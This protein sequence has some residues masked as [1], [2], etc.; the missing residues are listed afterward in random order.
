MLLSPS[1]AKSW[2]PKVKYI[3]FD[4]IHS[5]GQAEDGV[6]WEQLLLLAP[7]PI[8]A[9]SATVGNPEM[10]N[11]WLDSTQQSSGH[12]VAM[13]KHQHRYSDLRKFVFNPPKRF[14]FRGLSDRPSFATLGLDGISGFA[15]I[16]PVASLV[17]KSRGIPDDL[18]L[19]AR[20]CLSLYQ[21]MKR[22]ETA[23]YP[24][25]SDLEPSKRL[26]STKVIRKADIIEWEQTLKSLLKAW[27]SDSN[28]PF[29]AVQGELSKSMESAPSS[30]VEASK[31]EI[32]DKANDLTDIDPNDL[33]STTLPLLCKLQERDALPAILFNYDR[34]KCENIVKVVVQQLRDAEHRWKVSSPVWNAKL[35]GFEKWKL[36]K[37]KLGNKKAKVV[38]KKKGK[39]GDDDDPTSKMDNMMDA[40]SEEANPYANFDPEAPVDGFHFAAKHRAE[41]TELAAYFRQMKW[42]YVIMPYVA[43]C[44]GPPQWHQH[45][46]A[47]F[48]RF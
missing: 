42:R 10:F 7:C 13:I 48:P 6:V 1:N 5:I 36:E 39:G 32:S 41:A 24:V 27:M 4:E 22:H 12:K 38:P 35:G 43:R 16:H 34:H 15:F 8:I 11:S 20:D 19:E 45:F 40:A 28:S 26:G 46:P 29:D 2:S 30:E 47:L 9:L 3:I 25:P 17:N 33:Y 18:S 14:A 44:F 37:E 23:E 21:S 31:R